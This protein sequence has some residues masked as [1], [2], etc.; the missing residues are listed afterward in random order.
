MNNENVLLI[1]NGA[2]KIKYGMAGETSVPKSCYNSI[3]KSK[4]PYGE[5]YCIG[6]QIEN[7]K[8]LQSTTNAYIKRPK[9]FGMLTSWEIQSE[10]WDYCFY[11]PDEMGFDLNNYIE[12][13][14]DGDVRC[15]HLVLSETMLHMPELSK[16]TDEV[17]FEEYAFDSLYKSPSAGFIPFN[18]KH[19][20]KTQFLL[21]SN[22][23]IIKNDEKDFQN[24]AGVSY[25][26][27]QLVIDSGFDCTYVIPVINGCIYY[28]AVRKSNFG[29][30]FFTGFLK[31]LI[32]YRHIDLSQETLVVNKIKE[33]CMYAAPDS[34]IKHLNNA[35]YNVV[36]EFVLPSEEVRIENKS[37]DDRIDSNMGYLLKQDEFLP[38]GRVSLKLNDEL[39]TVPESILSPDKVQFDSSLKMSS[40]G[41]IELIQQSLNL[42]PDMIKPLLVSN[43]V[44]IGGNFNIPNMKNRILKELQL[45][46]PTEWKVRISCDEKK[47]D[48]FTYDSMNEFAKTDEYLQ[49]R[50]TR[51]EYFEHGLD[52]S[53]KKRFGYQAFL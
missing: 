37:L 35:K 43:I 15:P 44:L 16:N 22:D 31:N 5:I 27:F 2:Y 21:D 9:E 17:V 29:G 49:T 41:L 52:W 12:H 39:F 38:N 19:I 36:K 11:N 6:N 53:N 23:N 13:K 3:I 47:S 50:V 10:I 24:D 28:D 25:N 40:H 7:P 48:L 1:D 46:M 14:K 8:I 45:N 34:F 32:S 20:K 18:R 4:T 42:C 33:Q 26:K 30:K 51:E